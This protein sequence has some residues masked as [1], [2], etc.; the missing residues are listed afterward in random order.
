VTEEALL[1]VAE[2]FHGEFK[3]SA[4]PE[5]SRGFSIDFKRS[6]IRPRVIKINTF[7]LDTSICNHFPDV[8]VCVSFMLFSLS[9]KINLIGEMLIL[10]FCAVCFGLGLIIYGVFS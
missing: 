4:L 2:S 6:R 9:G 3:T 5:L 1:S 10:Y 8:Q 7:K